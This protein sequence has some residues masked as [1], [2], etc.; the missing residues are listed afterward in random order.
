[1]YKLYTNSFNEQNIIKTNTDGSTTCFAQ[2]PDNV[3]YQKYLEWVAD[4]NTIEE[5]D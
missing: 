2:N 4:G 5:A 1:M 3:D